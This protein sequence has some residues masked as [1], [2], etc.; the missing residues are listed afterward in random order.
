MREL[1]VSTGNQHKLSEIEKILKTAWPDSQLTLKSVGHLPAEL[2]RQYQPVEDGNT[3]AENA[4]IKAKALYRLINQPVIAEDS[5]LEVDA[6]QGAPGFHSARY[7][8]SDDQRIERILTSIK[9]EPYSEGGVQLLSRARFVACICLLLSDED[10]I[11]FFGTVDGHIQ[12]IRDGK[13]GFGYD[14]VFY[15]PPAAQ[16]FAAMGEEKM[17]VSHRFKALT[18]LFNFLAQNHT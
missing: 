18:K 3:Y 11:Y 1:F 7:G 16:T 5:G 13:A 4:L 14:P 12:A 10:A 2:Q 17:Q 9:A 8:D 6:L 15:Y